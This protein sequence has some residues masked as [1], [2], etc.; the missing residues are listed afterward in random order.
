M[1][2]QLQG[3]ERLL[4]I[5]VMAVSDTDKD[6]VSLAVWREPSNPGYTQPERIWNNH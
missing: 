6:G 4:Q 5:P 2:L 1:L 3:A